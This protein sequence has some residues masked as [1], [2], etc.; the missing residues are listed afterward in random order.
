[1]RARPDYL[2]Y[3]NEL[4]GGSKNGSRHLVDSSL[5]WGQELPGVKAWIDAHA[6]PNEPVFISYFGTGEPDYYGLQRARRL[7]FISVFNTP[8]TLVR[9]EPGLYCIS[10]TMLAHVYSDLRGPW[11]LAWENEYL[12]KREVAERL[13]KKIRTIDNWM[14]RGILPYYK[15]GRTVSFKWSDVQAHLDANCRVCRR[16]SSL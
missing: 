15:L 13:R 12:T 14:K 16:R 2:A 9:L 3:F 8:Q 11:T 10:A 1:M 5:D 6:R 7:P 4:V